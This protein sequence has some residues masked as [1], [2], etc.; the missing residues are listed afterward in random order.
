MGIDDDLRRMMEADAAMRRALE[1]MAGVGNQLRHE[2]DFLRAS[3]VDST[4]RATIDRMVEEQRITRELA[5]ASGID[6]SGMLTLANVPNS[7]KMLQGILPEYER[8]G[9]LGAASARSIAMN[10]A[11]LASKNYAQQFRMPV[12]TEIDR[13]AREASTASKFAAGFG[14]FEMPDSAMTTAMQAMHSPWLMRD[15]VMRSAHAFAEMQQ[16]GRALGTIAP[17]DE[18][19]ARSLRGALGDWRDVTTLP[20]PI[21]DNVVAR[22]DFYVGLGFDS[23]LTDFTAEAFDESAEL[24][25]LSDKADEGENNDEEIGLARINRAHNHLVRFERKVRRFI[26]AAMK[27]EFGEDWLQRQ[28]PDGMLDAWKA[29]KALEKGGEDQPLIAYADFTDY[30]RIIERKDN[31]GRVFKAIFKRQSDVQES[32][33]RLFPVRICT[34]HARLIT[35][36]DELLLQVETR[37]LGRVFSAF[38]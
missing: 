8:L 30:I 26:D 19:L 34:M 25:G 31:W 6:A 38:F 23:S 37:R 17:F 14:G 32:F 22:T 10:D 15:D 5:L 27:A 18:D 35:L 24:A 9:L 3:A 16:I 20:A 7:A 13:L 28:L 1:P 21:L 2:L 36:D 11:I 29:K 12:L 33:V 4:M